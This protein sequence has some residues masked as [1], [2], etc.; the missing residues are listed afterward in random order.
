[1]KKL[2]FW[3]EEL[4]AKAM[5][6]SLIPRLFI[7]EVGLNNLKIEYHPFQGKSDLEKNISKRI[8]KYVLPDGYKVAHLILRDQDA[9]DCKVIKKKLLESISMGTNCPLLVRIACHELESFYLAD[10]MAVENALHIPNL[11]LLQNKKT[12]RSP[13]SKRSPADLLD[14]ITEGIYQKVSGSREIGKF[15]D[16]YNQR[17]L[18]FYHLVKGIKSLLMQIGISPSELHYN[19]IYDKNFN[20]INQK[21]LEDLLLQDG[22]KLDSITI[23]TNLLLGSGITLDTQVETVIVDSLYRVEDKIFIL[24]EF[25]LK[26]DL[27]DGIEYIIVY[28]MHVTNDSFIA[29]LGS[30][31]DKD[32]I[33]IKG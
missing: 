24:K 9:G 4:S 13:D 15:L 31:V 27:F 20:E 18:S 29:N 19:A 2:V 6:E 28:A 17:S 21:E 8:G 26:P 23:L 32:R 10:L 11:R 30:F 22:A 14:K 25:E 7:N 12:Y 1:M 16:I 33:I 3:L 5:L